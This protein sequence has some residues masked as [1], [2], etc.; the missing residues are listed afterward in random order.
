MC[1]PVT[2]GESLGSGHLYLAQIRTFLLCV[3]RNLRREQPL[4]RP[5][6]RCLKSIEESRTDG[7]SSSG[8]RSWQRVK[9]SVARTD[10]VRLGP[11]GL[12]A[13]AVAYISECR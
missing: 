13:W 12:M 1:L 8:R 3:D 5:T 9:S 4:A 7:L 2:R 11:G 10:D 6:A